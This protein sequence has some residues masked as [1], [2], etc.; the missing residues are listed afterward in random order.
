MPD[1]PRARPVDELGRL[2]AQALRDGES[3][4]D[5]LGR[6]MAAIAATLDVSASVLYDYDEIHDT[7]DLLFFS[8]HPSD[9]RSVLHRRMEAL[10]L[11]RALERREPYTV[12]GSGQELLVPLYFRDTLE[13]VL[14]VEH[15]ES[16]F[17]LDEDV[18]DVCRLISRFLG[19]FMSSNR[20]AVNQKQGSLAARD[21]ERAREVQLTYLPSDYPVTERYEIFGYNQSSA[22]VGGDYFDFFETGDHRVQ[23]VLADACGHGLAAALVMS[24]FR[25]LL[26]A[27]VRRAD[28]PGT[29]F[30]RLNQHLYAAGGALSYLTSVFLDFHPDDGRLQYF[31]AGHFD[32]VLLRASGDVS[33]LRGGGPPLG[34]FPDAAYEGRHAAV[35]AGDVLLLFTDGLIELA[36][37]ADECFGIEGACRA[38]LANRDR[39]LSELASGILASAAEWSGRTRAHDDVTLFLMRFR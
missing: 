36:N 15:H 23:C 11:S 2:F 13:A 25:G 8:G 21:L 19:L 1:R 37:D 7:F 29:L 38:A 30:T 34:M 20:L 22:L 27:E 17:V 3:V 24:N 26:Q 14:L 4:N 32:P 5:F 28:D 6:F 18:A 9:A 31:N 10:N 16:P 12:D 39:P 33:R 35:S